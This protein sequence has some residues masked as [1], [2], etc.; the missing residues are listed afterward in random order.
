MNSDLT[1]E[2]VLT[3]AKREMADEH[4]EFA[5]FC[6]HYGDAVAIGFLEELCDAMFTRK[7]D[8][9]YISDVHQHNACNHTVTGILN[10]DGKEFCFIIE[11]GDWNGTVVRH[12]GEELRHFEPPPP[13]IYDMVPINPNL[14]KERPEMYRVYLAWKKL[15]WFQEL[16]RNYAYDRHFQPGVKIEGYYKNKALEKGLRIVRVDHE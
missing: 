11:S 9:I 13:P 1:T 4:P 14:E 7:S 5:K 15:D 10:H 3:G 12:F 2:E 8:R 16:L 6:A